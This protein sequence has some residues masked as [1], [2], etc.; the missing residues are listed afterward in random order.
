MTGE[1]EGSRQ[2]ER[3]AVQESGKKKYA[4]EDHNRKERDR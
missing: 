2:P 3:E 4:S 1:R